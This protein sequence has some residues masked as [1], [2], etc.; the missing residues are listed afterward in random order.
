MMLSHARGDL[1]SAPRAALYAFAGGTALDLCTA[2]R[3]E[4]G[5]CKSTALSKGPRGL[6]AGDRTGNSRS[7]QRSR[8][9][10]EQCPWHRIG[11]GQACQPGTALR[12]V[13]PSSPRRAQRMDALLRAVPTTGQ[14][15][16]QKALMPVSSF[17]APAEVCTRE[18]STSATRMAME[19][20]TV[21]PPSRC[22]QYY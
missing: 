14:S 7:H 1:G 19:A 20:A 8:D 21:A 15:E 2:F 11:A 10:S 13:G 18:A 16:R 3:Q 12:A 17:F 22:A 6:C 9:R 4:C 5:L